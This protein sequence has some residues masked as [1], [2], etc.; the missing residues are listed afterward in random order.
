MF[1]NPAPC[2]GNDSFAV[3]M[4]RGRAGLTSTSN[5]VGS[6]EPSHARILPLVLCIGAGIAVTNHIITVA[7]ASIVVMVVMTG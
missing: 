3:M 7:I 4:V 2:D 6:D 5:L 1:R